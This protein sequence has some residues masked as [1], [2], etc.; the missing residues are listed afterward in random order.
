MPDPENETPVYVELLT[1]KEKLDSDPNT[2]KNAEMI[3]KMLIKF[4]Q[5]DPKNYI[6]TDDISKI[7]G[8][9]TTNG[10]G[11]GILFKPNVEVPRGASF[12][13]VRPRQMKAYRAEL[14][15]WFQL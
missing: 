12:S 11:I 1:S 13:K 5:Q 9:L 8:T 10:G 2:S 4:S 6:S 14:D 7:K 15:F 3:K